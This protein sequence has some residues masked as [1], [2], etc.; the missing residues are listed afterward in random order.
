MTLMGQAV[1]KPK[2]AMATS[3]KVKI[4]DAQIRAAIK[5]GRNTS[6][7]AVPTT[8]IDPATHPQLV[9]VKRITSAKQKQRHTDLDLLSKLEGSV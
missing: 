5:R 4:F 2:M 6:V 9:V 1:S 7:I 8:N 3:P